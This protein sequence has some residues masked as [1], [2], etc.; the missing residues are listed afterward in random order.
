MHD[1]INS[2]VNYTSSLTSEPF[3]YEETKIVVEL[4]LKGYSNEQ[5]REKVIK[6]NIWAY[7]SKKQAKRLIPVILRRIIFLDDEMVHVLVNGNDQESKIVA[8]NLVMK[9]NLLFY[10]FI[11]E[12]YMLKVES[13]EKVILRAEMTDFF[14][15]K[16]QKSIV[17]RG[18]K[19]YVFRKLGQVYINILHKAGLI[20]DILDKKMSSVHINKKM[21]K[22]INLVL[23]ITNI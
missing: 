13:K 7:N 10:E 2:V 14:E 1:K 9:N 23:Y 5:I 22:Y 11:K 12:I 17:V 15:R 21:S 6:D 20:D 18:W 16:K 3:L 8:L 19:P 4:K